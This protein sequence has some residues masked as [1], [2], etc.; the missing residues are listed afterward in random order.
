MPYA[1]FDTCQVV[2]GDKKV[3]GAKISCGYCSNTADINVNTHAIGH[4]DDDAVMERHVSA[5]F[6]KLGWKLG[7]SKF[8][9]AC[10]K[11][12]PRF[13]AQSMQKKIESDAAA[14]AAAAAKKVVPITSTTVL[15][16]KDLEPPQA[17]RPMTPEERRIIL[18]K[19]DEVYPNGTLG[20]KDGWNDTRVSEDL[21]VARPWVSEMRDMLCGPEFGTQAVKEM[22]EARMVVEEIKALQLEQKDFAE[23]MN[24]YT[25]QMAALAVKADTIMHTLVRIEDRK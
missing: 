12:L 23:Q 17:D 18:S 16:P 14:A 7:K 3:R 20:Y 24:A 22:S 5:K 13:K 11:C 21:G 9:H 6:E 8:K 4:G 2:A 19:L 10:P 15:P 1:L 25:T